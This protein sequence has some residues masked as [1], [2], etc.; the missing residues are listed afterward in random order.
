MENNGSFNNASGTTK[1][2]GMV[3][4]Y[5]I[6]TRINFLTHAVEMLQVEGIGHNRV[7]QHLPPEWGKNENQFSNQFS[8]QFSNQFLYQF[9]NQFFK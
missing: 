8:D 5:L 9:S 3:T 7:G 1:L 6:S 4:G 2:K